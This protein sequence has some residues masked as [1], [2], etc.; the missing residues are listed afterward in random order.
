[1]VIEAAVRGMGDVFTPPFRSVLFRSLAITFALLAAIW[2][3]GTRSLAWLAG[4]YA[5]SHPVG[6]PWYD[7]MVASAAGILSGAALIVGLS[8]LIAPITSIVAGLF[9]DSAAE[10]I[11][12]E[13]YPD[14]RPGIA[15]GVWESIVQAIRFTG[16]VV[17]VNL[18]AL[19]LLLI[20]GVNLI[21]FFAGNGYLLG[22]EYFEFA[23]A[24][25]IGTTEARRL[26]IAHGGRVFLGGLLIA[27]VLAVPV[28]N[29][30]TPLF[31]TALMVHLAKA[32]L[33]ARPHPRLPSN[34]A[35]RG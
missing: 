30:I 19:L 23:A 16:L 35:P 3:L 14:D 33:G 4:D 1:M 34:V 18:L 31:A 12:R 11:E 2:V 7:T 6:V 8:F 27:G 20:P 28:L 15:M 24:R 17:L 29:L 13:T 5:A 26:R 32:A 9:L 10:A 21:A 25:Y 22:R